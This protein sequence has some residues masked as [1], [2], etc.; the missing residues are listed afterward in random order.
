MKRWISVFVMV[1]ALGSTAP[2]SA[3]A[4]DT[5][6]QAAVDMLTVLNV[7]RTM[8]GATTAMT[9]AMIQ[10]NP[11]LTPYR[12]VMLAWSAKYLTWEN[13]GPKVVDLYVESFSETE[14]REISAF[15]KTPT[16]SKALVLMPELMGKGAKIGADLMQQYGPELQE[17]LKARAAELERANT[18]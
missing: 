1:I 7:E 8:V 14:L 2:V 11:A 5:H 15:Y 6:R 4:P 16:G 18:P 3:G 13:I 12:D 9:D 10:G 17:M